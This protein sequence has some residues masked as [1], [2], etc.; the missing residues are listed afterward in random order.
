MI[1][2][3]TRVLVVDDD[4]IA[5]EIILEY[6]DG[7]QVEASTAHDGQ[8]GWETLE[9]RAGEFDVILLDR[10][11]PRLNGIQLLQRIRAD[12][13]F[14][15]LPVIM[16]TSAADQREVLEGI[17]AGAYY[18]LTK[19]FRKEMLRSIVR[20]AAS[21][22]ARVKALRD[23]LRKQVGVLN[24]LRTGRFEF[25]TL[26][27]AM[28]LGAFLARAFPDPDRVL[29]GL[30]ELLVNAVEHGNLEL[31]YDDK[32]RLEEL[33]S[34][35]EEIERRLADSSLGG[36][37][38]VAELERRAESVT[39]TIRD[40]GQGFDPEPYLRVDPARLFD[41]HGRG[42]LIAKTMSFDELQYR[43]RGREV[44]AVVKTGPVP[45]PG[46]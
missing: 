37:V 36:R 5:V 25:R 4:P 35:R 30:S 44:V 10:M 40:Q 33:G 39:V 41:T 29:I 31:S 27:E 9:A 2:T 43:D 19:P 15:A 6:L 12:E 34:W 28:D 24:L 46:L 7:M 42:I 20:A 3:P 8:A 22:Y 13:R 1:G 14:E 18:Y 26:G 38:A 45:P 11:M 21:D 17:Q 32:G 16:Q 23:E